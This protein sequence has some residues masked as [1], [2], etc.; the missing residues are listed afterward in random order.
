MLNYLYR[1]KSEHGGYLRQEAVLG[2]MPAPDATRFNRDGIDALVERHGGGQPKRYTA[3]EQ[4][5]I[6]R[7]MRREPDRDKDQTATWSLATLQGAARGWNRDPP[8]FVWGGK[9]QARR[10]RARER[11]RT[12]GGSGAYTRQ[13]LRR[14]KAA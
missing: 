11:Q 7:E 3:P 1:L 6:L 5:R 2:D 4:E 14:R 10:Q 8:P 9:R 13:P 12:L